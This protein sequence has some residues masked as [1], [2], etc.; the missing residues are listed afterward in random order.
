MPRLRIRFPYWDLAKELEA[1]EGISLAE[2]VQRVVESAV[3]DAVDDAVGH[4]ERGF[5]ALRTTKVNLES[6]REIYRR[7]HPRESGESARSFAALAA[8]QPSAP[9]I[10]G[11]RSAVETVDEQKQAIERLWPRNSINS[12][13]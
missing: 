6:A 8:E 5:R 12:K 9:E 3:E 4:L 13:R 10:A 1:E 2:A 11:E 7:H